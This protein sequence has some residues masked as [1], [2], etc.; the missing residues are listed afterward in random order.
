VKLGCLKLLLLMMMLYAT[1][2]YA[3]QSQAN[4]DETTIYWAKPGFEPLYI[5]SG[6]LRNSGIGDLTISAIGKLLPQYQHKTMRANYIRVISELRRRNKVCAVLHKTPEREEFSLFSNPLVIIPS[7][8]VYIHSSDKGRFE[9]LPGWEE[10]KVSFN[11]LLSSRER[12]RM[13][14]TPSHSYGNERDKII[15]KNRKNLDIVY[16]YAGQKS[17]IKMLLAKRVD[18]ILEFPWVVNHH[19]PGLKVK[20]SQLHKILLADVPSN[21]LA[22][23]ACPKSPWGKEVIT[24]LNNI[25]PP[26]HALTK[27]YVEK[28]LTPVEVEE[29]RRAN[30][31]HFGEVW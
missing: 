23:I 21:Q 17:L 15:Q 28:W 27:P 19:L 14:Q 22:F 9:S 12:L 31:E 18:L 11:D 3:Q 4:D 29:Y 25:E 5:P 2:A 7:Y 6:A 20:S 13:A 1:M 30:R 10:G 26:L 24:A 16:G 8:Q